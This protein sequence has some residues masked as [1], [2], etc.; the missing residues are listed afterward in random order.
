MKSLHFYL[1]H[2]EYISDLKEELQLL[3]SAEAKPFEILGSIGDGFLC[4]G[5]IV[6]PIFAQNSWLNCQK[7]TFNSISEAQKFLKENGKN[8]VAYKPHLVRRISLIEEK[9]HRYSPPIIRFPT[10]YRFLKPQAWTLLDEKTLL[11]SAET[12]SYFPLGYWNF[13]EDKTAPSRAFLKLWEVFLRLNRW[14]SPKDFCLDMGS[15]PGGWTHVLN[16]LG[17]QV[18]SVDRSPLEA[19]LLKSPRVENKLMDAFKLNPE[20]VQNL[21]WFFSDLIC[22]PEKLLELVQRWMEVHPKAQFICT[23]KFQGETDFASLEKFKKIPNSQIFHLF[24]NKHEVT[25]VHLRQD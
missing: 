4:S 18:L 23:I 22:Y 11:W 24:V 6:N 16:Q 25:W 7:V 13:A 8:W 2:P 21:D 3:S 14:P 17:C 15:C 9:I 12:D 1:G 10:D 5:E 19:Q 20:S